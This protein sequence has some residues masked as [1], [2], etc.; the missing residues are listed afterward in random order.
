MKVKENVIYKLVYAIV[1]LNMPEIDVNTMQN[2][3]HP[4]HLMGFFKSFICETTGYMGW[5]SLV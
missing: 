3:V 2:L 5:F 1:Y 4:V